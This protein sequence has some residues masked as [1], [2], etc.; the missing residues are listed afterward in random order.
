MVLKFQCLN[1][2]NGVLLYPTY[3]FIFS[4]HQLAQS[5]VIIAQTSMWV[6]IMSIILVGQALGGIDRLFPVNNKYD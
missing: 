6:V 3:L 4:M 2:L 1:G 5:G